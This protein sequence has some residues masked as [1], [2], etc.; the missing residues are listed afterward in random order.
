[1]SQFLRGER[2][3]GEGQFSDFGISQTREAIS[4]QQYA[5]RVLLFKTLPLLCFCVYIFIL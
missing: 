3:N 1:M 4:I 5:V 2:I